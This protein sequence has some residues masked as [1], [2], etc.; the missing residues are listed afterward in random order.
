LLIYGDALDSVRLLERLAWDP[1]IAFDAAGEWTQFSPALP[2]DGAA[3][4]TAQTAA[5][6][7]PLADA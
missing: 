7:M 2:P 5:P 4:G 6:H 3:T 1:F